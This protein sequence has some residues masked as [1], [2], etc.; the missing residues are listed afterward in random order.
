M[1]YIAYQNTAFN[2][3]IE[4]TLDMI[5][6]IY[7][8]DYQI[9]DYQTL[10]MLDEESSGVITYGREKPPRLLRNHIHI[11]ESDLFSGDYLKPQSMPRTPL[12]RYKGLPIIYSGCGQLD[13]WVKKSNNSIETNIDIIASSFFMLSRY[14]EVVIDAKDRYER[15]PATASLAYKENFLDRPIVNEYIE[16]LWEWFRSLKPELKR[17][18]LWPDNKDFAICL[19]H[20]V[21]MIRKYPPLLLILSIGGALLRQKKPK[22]AFDIALEYLAI[23][24]HLRKEPYDTFDYIT[25]LEKS[26]G[27]KSSFYFKAGGSSRQDSS[28]TIRKSRVRRIMRTLEREGC[29]IGLHPSFNSYTNLRLMASEKSSLD[30]LVNNK[31]YGC[32]QHVIRWKTPVTWRIQEQLG[33]L[34]DTTLGFADHIGFRCG[35]CLP[36]KPFDVVEN[37]RLNI[38]ELPLTMMEG[39]LLGL[40]YQSFPPEE[41]Y[42]EI[43]RHIKI[44]KKFRGVF[45]LLWHNSCLEDS[46]GQKGWSKVY[47]KVMKYVSRQGAFVGS[48]RDIIAWWN[49]N[50]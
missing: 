13:S 4:Y 18:P 27:F 36:F 3:Q 45:V 20:D 37:R 9:I 31:N 15:F 1:L 39:S 24:L 22:L 12:Q 8:A 47:E 6:S 41:A 48:G 5:L 11:Y 7:G 16:L 2:L 40:S 21:D 32:R 42:K 34:Y 33:F 30:K 44:V 49:E 35:I 26:S 17:K 29:E 25:N 14:E 10:P 50:I 28:D 23:L 19:T 46:G 38:W 43:I